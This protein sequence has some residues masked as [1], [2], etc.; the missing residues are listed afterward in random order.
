M[1]VK[2]ALV[3]IAFVVVYAAAY[4]HLYV[5]PRDRRDDERRWSDL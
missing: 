2:A 1:T 5:G 3:L 4:A